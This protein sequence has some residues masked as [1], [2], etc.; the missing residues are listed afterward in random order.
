MTKQIRNLGIF[1][2]LCYIALFVQVN[3]LTVF[4]AKD[5]Q[6]KPGNN[7]QAVRDFDRPRG[8]ISTAD[9]VVLAQTVPDTNPDDRLELQR[10]YPEGDTFGQITGFFNPLSIG[11]DGLEKEYN[12]ELAG[13]DLTDLTNLDGIDR[14][15]D[16][17]FV[18]KD[19]VGNLSL[20]IRADVQ[21]AAR[22][23]LGDVPGSV[24][25]LDPKTGGIL[26]LWSF[27]SYDPNL[28]SVHNGADATA[29]S[30]ALLADPTKPRLARAYQEIYPPG[31]TYKVVT[32][33]GGVEKGTVTADEP[34]YPLANEYRA[35]GAGSPIT[36]FDDG[37]CGGKLF[38][39][40]RVSCNTA[41]AQMGVD[42]V[43]TDAMVATAE[44][45][46]FNRDVPI[47]LP[48]P[49]RSQFPNAKADDPGFLAQISIGQNDVA[50]T[51]L[52]MAMVA[53]AV[54][55]GGKIMTPHV[56]SEIRDEDERVV[57][58]YEPDVWTE[59]MDAGS[60][61][62][63]RQAMKEVATEG[64]AQHL[65]DDIPE[66]EV[67]GKTGTA[68]FREDTSH[69]WVI[70]FAGP[71]GEDPQVV[72][73]VIVEAQPGVSEATGG[74]V[75]APIASQVLAAALQPLPAPGEGEAPTDGGSGG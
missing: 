60:A 59:V 35:R 69:A 2:T 17:F 70:G 23:A 38:E 11:T 49:A 29:A 56:L 26:A 30:Q 50:A 5:L 53:A 40:L 54:A 25:A 20:T 10:T 19:H 43:G 36:N 37:T 6:N 14:F 67:G 44:S 18:D 41:F 13:R 65:G 46:G 1:L 24:V 15:V 34:D 22:E 66:F 51:P 72:V 57:R 8:S 74:R 62:L 12:S 39:I 68:Q 27:P 4:D 7:R 28:L 71:P 58:T 48:R 63:L 73:A 47:D 3:R 55:N 64:T 42:Q 9:G 61:G 31:S 52:Q 45:Y 21:R 32:A 75:A 16:D 33:T